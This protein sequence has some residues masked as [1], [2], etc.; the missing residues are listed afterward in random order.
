MEIEKNYSINKP[1][2]EQ[3]VLLLDNPDNEMSK[4]HR[5]DVSELLKVDEIKNIE[6]EISYLD[7]SISALINVFDESNF[8]AQE[9][10]IETEGKTS[11]ELK[12]EIDKLNTDIDLKMKEYQDKLEVLSSFSDK[13][14]DLDF[15]G[16]L[17]E[18]EDIVSDIQTTRKLLEANIELVKKINEIY[19]ETLLSEVDLGDYTDLLDVFT[20]LYYEKRKL[21]KNL[22]KRF[23]NKDEI[24]SLESKKKILK[25][26]ETKY[27]NILDSNYYI[28]DVSFEDTKDKILGT[29]SFQIPN[30]YSELL[31]ELSSLKEENLDKITPEIIE[32]L[33]EDYIELVRK[34]IDEEAKNSKANDM[35]HLERHLSNKVL[36]KE[37]LDV[38]KEGLSQTHE[39]YMDDNY[40]EEESRKIKALDQKLMLM[41]SPLQNIIRKHMMRGQNPKT[42]EEEFKELFSYLIEF[43]INIQKKAIIDSFN[44]LSALSKYNYGFNRNELDIKNSLK[45]EN[46]DDLVEEINMDKLDAFSSNEKIFKIYSKEE[47]DSFKELIGKLIFDKLLSIPD[48]NGESINLGYKALH[49]KNPKAISYNILNF[50]RE[51]GHSGEMP[52]L[53]IHNVSQNTLGAKYINSLTDNQIKEVEELNIPGV[54][55]IINLIKEHPDK[56][57]DHNIKNGDDYAENPIYNQTQNALEEMC[58]HYLEK[59][60][61]EEKYF[62]LTV[63][64]R[65]KCVNN[66]EENEERNTLIELISN[67]IGLEEKVK[68]NFKKHHRTFFSYLRD[69]NRTSSNINSYKNELNSLSKYFDDLAD[70]LIVAK[71][72]DVVILKSKE[73]EQNTIES[74]PKLLE[75]LKAL[76]DEFVQ[77]QLSDDKYKKIFESKLLSVHSDIFGSEDAVKDI[78]TYLNTEFIELRDFIDSTNEQIKDSPVK[79]ILESEQM[80]LLDGLSTQNNVTEEGEYVRKYLKTLDNKDLAERFDLFDIQIKTALAYFSKE[81][82]SFDKDLLIPLLSKVIEKEQSVTKVNSLLHGLVHVKENKEI[83]EH[84]KNLFKEHPNAAYDLFNNISLVNEIIDAEFNKDISKIFNSEKQITD[85]DLNEKII[86]EINKQGLSEDS[87]IL[88]YC[89]LIQIQGK[90][91]KD[92]KIFNLMKL[93]GQIGRYE[94]EFEKHPENENI[95]NQLNERKEKLE[96]ILRNEKTNSINSAIL[97]VCSRALKDIVGE[98]FEIKEINDDL[99]N[100]ILV[101]HQAG[102]NQKLLSNLIKDHLNEKPLEIYNDERNQNALKEYTSLGIDT[103]KW[104]KGIERTYKPEKQE[105]V[106]EAKEARIKIYYEEAINIYSILDME[107]ENEDVFEKYEEIKNRKDI[108]ENILRDLKVQINAIKSLENAVFNSKIGDVKIYVEQD[109]FKVLQMGN[110]VSGSCLGLSKGNTFST[111]ANAVDVNKQI[112]YAEM[113]GEIVGR[114]L[115]ALN[116]ESKIVQFQTFNNRL[117]LDIDVLFQNYLIDLSKETNTEISTNGFVPQIVSQRWYNDG[118]QPF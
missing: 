105:N 76:D 66:D 33:E 53:S 109:P 95:K 85:Y 12:I 100:A 83:S 18:I 43:P 98:S 113:D 112:L 115:I 94:K 73:R 106:Q 59:G 29:I 16:N 71:H 87:D 32:S 82:H 91:M 10:S 44:N 64:E 96:L 103:E 90:K 35:H 28:G 14:I 56:F 4:E 9:I 41:Q 36:I 54:I 51:S 49:F 67:S 2:E 17:K 15:I 11:D 65:L 7:G 34:E 58:K 40:N 8:E 60:N 84:L 19:K 55:D 108:D 1:T 72:P 21:G 24:K 22:Y 57:N 101:Y 45:Y 31:K 75:Y 52:F 47:L 81:I 6:E 89:N 104:L 80:R 68:I 102:M 50:W 74:L 3:E 79:A 63:V 25:D 70:F 37:A 92:K 5:S 30:K 78:F 110:V 97:K 117:D 93:K 118:I 107:V 99:I 116:D 114:K 27:N 38:L 88:D 42:I 48:H 111:V 46:I 39:I 13:S 23:V 69:F 26:V 62:V 61:N 20:K 86:G 77:K